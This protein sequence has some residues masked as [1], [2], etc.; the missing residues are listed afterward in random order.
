MAGFET[1]IYDPGKPSSAI[2]IDTLPGTVARYVNKKLEHSL[3]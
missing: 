1:I 3:S 2:L